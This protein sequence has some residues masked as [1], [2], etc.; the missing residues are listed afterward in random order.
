MVRLIAIF[1]FDHRRH[2]P[3]ITENRPSFRAENKT[4]PSGAGKG[5]K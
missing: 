1:S 4:K 2:C 3:A 5:I